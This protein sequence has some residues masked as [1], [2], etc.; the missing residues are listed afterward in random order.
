V[1][2]LYKAVGVGLKTSMGWLGGT[3]RRWV[4]LMGF[5]VT[6]AGIATFAA[7]ESLPWAWLA[8]GGLILLVVSAAWTA[9][10]EHKLRVALEGSDLRLALLDRAIED[11]RALR[12]IEY[13]EGV[14]KAYQDWSA[15]TYGQLRENW[16]L[17]EAIGFSQVGNHTPGQ[18]FLRVADAQVAYL[19]K[20]RKRG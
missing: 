11:G 13:A 16:G 5:A 8:I 14:V 10:D 4:A 2:S 19:E 3:V 12:L 15:A 17:A 20:L 6:L 1:W 18:N 7:T 9:R